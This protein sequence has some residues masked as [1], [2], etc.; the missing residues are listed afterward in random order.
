MSDAESQTEE[1]TPSLRSQ[2]S[3]WLMI[4]GGASCEIVIESPCEGV[5]LAAYSERSTWTSA[6]LSPQSQCVPRSWEKQ[7]LPGDGRQIAK[8]AF[9]RKF[10]QLSG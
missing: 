8:A 10:S 4:M 1:S 2:L 6:G 7:L 5:A 9:L 3:T